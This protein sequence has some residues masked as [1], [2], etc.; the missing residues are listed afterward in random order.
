LIVP[1]AKKAAISQEALNQSAVA[2]PVALN[3][4]LSNNPG[5]TNLNVIDAEAV[6]ADYV[7]FDGDGNLITTTVTTSTTI[8]QSTL[9]ADSS[10]DQAAMAGIVAGIIFCFL[11]LCFII[12]IVCYM[13]S[14]RNSEPNLNQ[15]NQNQPGTDQS[16]SE[17]E[18]QATPDIVAGAQPDGA[19]RPAH[20]REF[21][22]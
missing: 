3:N 22:V 19:M 12:A 4:A 15:G 10:T 16:E 7:E 13:C 17:G 21:Q 6:P 2:L 5:T 20:I 11:F 18:P 8:V 9:E 14:Q 1:I